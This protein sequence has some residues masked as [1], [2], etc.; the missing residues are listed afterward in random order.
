MGRRL[1]WFALAAAIAVAFPFLWMLLTALKPFEEAIRHPPTVLPR[2]PTLSNLAGV[3]ADL[4]HFGLYLRNSLVAAGATSALAVGTSALAGYAFGRFRFRGDR[5]LFG[6]VL[7]SMFVPFEVTLIPNHRLIRWLGLED[8]LPAL[9]LPFGASAFGIFLVRQFF[10]SLPRDC[11]DAARIDG[12]GPWTFLWRVAI[13]L[14]RAP[15]ATVAWLSFLGSW[16]AL[17]WPLLVTSRP[18]TRTLAVGVS[19]FLEAENAQPQ[20]L[21]AGAALSLLPIALLYLVLGRRVLAAQAA[22]V[23]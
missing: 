10:R 1:P 6:A 2:A 9:F 17:L 5:V 16:N 14:A 19:L 23:T 3:F 13:P 20:M 18:E 21:M 8:T 22:W 15:L 4:P 7:A 11:W 12:C